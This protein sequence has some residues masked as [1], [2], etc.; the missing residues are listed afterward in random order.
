MITRKNPQGNGRANAYALALIFIAIISAISLKIDADR[1]NDKK[2]MRRIA[3]EYVTD[4]TGKQCFVK[5]ETTLAWIPCR[6]IGR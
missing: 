2:S 4:E 6:E 5:T 3:V 1:D